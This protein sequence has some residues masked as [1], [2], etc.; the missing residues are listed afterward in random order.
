MLM[1]PR[2][3]KLVLW[4]QRDRDCSNVGEELYNGISIFNRL[5]SVRARRSLVILLDDYLGELYEPRSVLLVAHGL[6][7]LLRVMDGVAVNILQPEWWGSY[8]KQVTFF[9]FGC[10][11]SLFF[12]A[13]AL[14]GRFSRF[15]GFNC[16]V[17]Y[18][19]GS[20][21]AKGYIRSHLRR[22]GRIFSLA[23]GN[24]QDFAETIK[25]EFERTI[26]EIVAGY[27]PKDGDRF[28]LILLEEQ[29]EGLCVI[30]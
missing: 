30:A 13:Y 18:Y 6:G 4:D 26:E 15:V 21:R 12:E 10:F 11:S 7:G 16:R 29:I 23:D 28:N 20:P 14:H 25:K 27:S 1:Y 2:K 19:I 3:S 24:L 9:G 17:Y 8:D 5:L 22:V